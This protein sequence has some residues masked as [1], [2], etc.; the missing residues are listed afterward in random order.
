VNRATRTAASCPVA[1]GG[2]LFDTGPYQ[3][4]NKL[5]AFEDVRPIQV[6]TGGVNRDPDVA[7]PTVAAPSAVNGDSATSGVAEC[8]LG[9]WAR[10]SVE[11]ATWCGRANWCGRAT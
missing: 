7:N 10:S 9:V 4:C 8:T 6:D 11:L 2:A 3:L 1:C 5:P